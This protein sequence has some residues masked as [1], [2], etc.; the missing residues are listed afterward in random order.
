METSCI[1]VVHVVQLLHYIFL[2]IELGER[3]IL[4]LI[5]LVITISNLFQAWHQQHTSDTL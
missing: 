4:V 5:Y 3:V 1:F 2:K